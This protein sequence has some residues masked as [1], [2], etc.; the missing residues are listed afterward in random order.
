MLPCPAATKGAYQAANFLSH[1]TTELIGVKHPAV[2]AHKGLPAWF[3]QIGV[4]AGNDLL[5]CSTGRTHQTQSST[6]PSVKSAMYAAKFAVH[7]CLLATLCA[8]RPILTV[9]RWCEVDRAVKTSRIH[10]APTPKPT[11]G[12]CMPAGRHGSL[13]QCM[14]CSANIAMPGQGSSGRRI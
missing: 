3:S 6:Q 8:C 1:V 7:Y 10:P 12:Q 5:Q 4:L 2:W 14:S 9:K 13:M 11:F